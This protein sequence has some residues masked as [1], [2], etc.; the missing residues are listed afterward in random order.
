MQRRSG[1]A[2]SILIKKYVSSLCFISTVAVMLCFSSVLNGQNITGINESDVKRE[3]QSRGLNES[4]FYEKLDQAGLT[5]DSIQYYTSEKI[6]IIENIILDLENSLSGIEEDSIPTTNIDLPLIIPSESDSI[7]IDSSIIIDEEIF[8]YGRQIFKDGAIVAD[9]DSYN[10]NKAPGSYTLGQGD[11]LS[12]SIYGSS[13][14]DESHEINNQGFI[15]ILNGAVRVFLKGITLTKAKE[16]L[17]KAYQNY[18]SFGAGEFDVNLNYS[19]QV[20]VNVYGEVVKPGPVTLPA[21][22]NVFSAIATAFGP[23]AIGSVRNIEVIKS[24]GKRYSFDVFD[25]MKNPTLQEGSYLDDGD[26]IF[27]PPAEII[28]DIPQGVRRPY[29]YELKTNETVGDLITFAGGF[30]ENANN[31]LFNIQRNEGKSIKIIDVLWPSSKNTKLQNGDLIYINILDRVLDKYVIINGAVE[32]EGTF[33]LSSNMRVLDLLKRAKLQDES[34]RD[35]AFLKRTNKDSTTSYIQ[36]NIDNILQNPNGD[37]NIALINKDE[38]TIW[39]LKRFVDNATFAVSGAIREEGVFDFDKNQNLKITDAILLGGG[40]R[41]DASNTLIIHRQDPLNPKIKRYHTLSNLNELLEDPQQESNIALE[42]FDSL[43][44][45]SQNDFLE[46]SYITIQGAVNNPGQFQYGQ[47]MK[48]KDLF[49]LAGGFKLSAA[50][51]Q[52]E[53]SR[54][55]IENNQPTNV[56]VANIILDREF[57]IVGGDKDVKLGPYDIITVRYVPEFELQKTVFIGGEVKY[58]GPYTILNDNEKVSNIIKRAGSLTSEAFPAGATMNREEA[59]LGAVVIK[60]DEILQKENSEFNFIVQ[61]G[62]RIYIPK[63]KEFVTIEGATKAK[64]IL[65][66]GAINLNNRIHVPFQEGKRAMY[67][68][69]EYAGGLS[70]NADRN[71]IFVEHPNGEIKKSAII[72]FFTK[73]PVVRKGSTIRVRQKQKKEEEDQEVTTDWGNVLQDTLNKAFTVITLLIAIQ[74]LN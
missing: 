48:I 34:R 33:E 37:G 25:Y 66:E 24:S 40:L 51:D 22:N 39:N 36:L 31:Q 17:K 67:Y 68:I 71:S 16:K 56:L 70:D 28:V 62:D 5:L 6:S 64:T 26:V 61:D 7:D 3:L 58:P 8:R 10:S 63:Q 60:L 11:I 55:M 35:V 9:S 15:R 27:V 50:T 1:M 23:T 53:V 14:I 57:N 46:D 2:L 42:P 32:Q 20:Q 47:D 52:I 74:S 13:K 19:R 45:Y 44:I 49:T 21:Y 43:F 72:L 4:K 59:N 73:T 54:I 69:N 12:I 29:K 38:I 41:R 18:Y 30:E 65:S